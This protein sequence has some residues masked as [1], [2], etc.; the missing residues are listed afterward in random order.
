[1][2]DVSKSIL[3]C[4]HTISRLAQREMGRRWMACAIVSLPHMSELV[5]EWIR[6]S[7]SAHFM[8]FILLA[9]LPENKNSFITFLSK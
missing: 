7:Q 2:Y 8:R 1:M 4:F 9:L 3:Y 6:V 5:T